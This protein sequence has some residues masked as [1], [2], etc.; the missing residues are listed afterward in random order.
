VSAASAGGGAAS[1]GAAVGATA[2]PGVRVA[3]AASNAQ[4]ANN[5]KTRDKRIRP[6]FARSGG[7]GKA[8]LR[9]RRG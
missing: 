4:P 6:A 2:S 1:V 7:D 5:P 8:L 9:G 3:Q